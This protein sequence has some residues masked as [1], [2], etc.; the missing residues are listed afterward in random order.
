[1]ATRL[2]KPD[3]ATGKPGRDEPYCVAECDRDGWSCGHR[4]VSMASAAWCGW[5]KYGPDLWARRRQA[6]PGRHRMA[7]TPLYARRNPASTVRG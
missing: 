7:D 4:H 6:R 1:V 2:S 5:A 3:M